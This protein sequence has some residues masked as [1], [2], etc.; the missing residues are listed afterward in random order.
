MS[1]VHFPI[2]KIALSPNIGVEVTKSVYGDTPSEVNANLV[3]GFRWFIGFGNIDIGV[4]LGDVS[5]GMGGVTIVPKPKF[6]R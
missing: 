3:L 2:R 5:S 6:N 1:R 4:K